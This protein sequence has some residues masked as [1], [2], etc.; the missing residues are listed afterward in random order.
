MT[1]FWR[2]DWQRKLHFFQNSGPSDSFQSVYRAGFKQ[3]SCFY[4]VEIL[5]FSRT[6]FSGLLFMVRRSTQYCSSW[7]SRG[8]SLIGGDNTA[9][10]QLS[11]R[12]QFCS[13]CI[14]GVSVEYPFSCNLPCIAGIHPEIFGASQSCCCEVKYIGFW[15]GKEDPKQKTPHIPSMSTS[16]AGHK[17]QL[18]SPAVGSPIGGT[19]VLFST[20]AVSPWKFDLLRY[21]ANALTQYWNMKMLLVL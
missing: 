10:F 4:A 17:E 8:Q 21:T 20:P 16:Q 15:L 9:A 11:W 1:Q 6:L 3:W 18:C 5:A 19:G 13:D 12:N 7:Q 2:N 14:S